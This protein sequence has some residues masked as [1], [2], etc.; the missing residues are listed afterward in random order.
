MLI[1]RKELLVHAGTALM[2]LPRMQ[3]HHSTVLTLLH[4]NDLHGHAYLPG[5]AQ[6]LVRLAT[7][8]R[9]VRAEMPNVVLLD[10]GDIIHGTPEEKTFNGRPLLTAMN[11][12]YYDAATAGNHE[13]D[14]GQEVTRGAIDLARFPVLSANVVEDP[15]GK[16]WGGLKPYTVL[17]R[18]GVRIGV[19]G[20]TTPTTVQLQ[21][22]R[23][24]AGIRFTDPLEAASRLVTHLRT[25]EKADVVVFLSHLG[26]PA[27]RLMAEQTEGIDV[28]LGGHTHTV[29]SE[30]VWVKGT[31]IQQTGAL[32][33]A[34]G[35]VDLVVRRGSATEPGRVMG[36]NGQDNRWWGKANVPAPLE[37]SY[38]VRPLIYLEETNP[39]DPEI[40][41]VYRPFSD[42]MREKLDEVLTT[43]QEALPA[44]EAVRRETAVGNLVADAVRAQTGAQ[45]SLAAS[46]L[47]DPEGLAAGPVRV[48]DLYRLLGSYTR[49]HLV[50]VR[51]TGALLAE[52]LSRTGADPERLPLHLSGVRFTPGGVITVGGK[53]VENDARYTIGAAAHLIQ[54]FLYGKP[55]VEVMA[56]GTSAATVRD[57]LIS[58]LRGHAPLANRTD[59][60]WS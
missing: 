17:E 42:P 34:L 2:P 29:L 49:Q 44:R 32:G 15:T 12:L 13:F 52:M 10:A 4:T 47:I 7:L 27:D 9:R 18:G 53:A 41:R 23:T 40:L 37:K 25:V 38:P 30:Q 46:S 54:D 56:D 55:G 19:F 51:V 14:F 20:L 22:P 8:I 1:T 11:A 28:I 36:I 24:L 59:T 3:S 45:V 50:T 57:S 60:R 5:K 35:R 16:P 21:W 26:Y 48:R 43:A 39:D 31:L 33:K 6:G 58:Y